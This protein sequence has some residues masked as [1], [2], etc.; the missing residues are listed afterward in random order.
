MANIL[1]VDDDLV[2]LDVLTAMLEQ[3]HHKVWRVG[4]ARD[5]MALLQGAGRIDLAIIDLVLRDT[6]GLELVKQARGRLPSL[7]IIAI[8]GYIGPDSK[9]IIATLSSLGVKH[10][11]GKPIERRA[12]LGAVARL[13]ARTG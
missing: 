5:A 3:D 7:P 13:L 11:L 6:S 4:N 10:A 2:V 12:L 9:E 1:V 8:S